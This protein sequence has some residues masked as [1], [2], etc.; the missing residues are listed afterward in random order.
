MASRTRRD[1]RPVVVVKLRERG[2]VSP[3][4]GFSPTGF[5]MWT[6]RSA[7]GSDRNVSLPH[8]PGKIRGSQAEKISAVQ[9]Q[10]KSI[11]IDLKL[12]DDRTY[13]AKLEN[14]LSIKKKFLHQLMEQS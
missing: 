9:S 8:A 14:I 1:Q 4:V 12:A 7:S 13:R 3:E 5:G 10:I 6:R 11:T 2:H